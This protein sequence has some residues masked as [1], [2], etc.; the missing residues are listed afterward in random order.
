M[1]FL[2][3][4]NIKDSYEYLLDLKPM[5]EIEKNELINFVMKNVQKK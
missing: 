3:Q 2:S 5:K 4:F 1:P